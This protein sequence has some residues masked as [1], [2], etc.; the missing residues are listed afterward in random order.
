[1]RLPPDLMCLTRHR[2]SSDAK[3]HYCENAQFRGTTRLL[4]RW[5]ARVRRVVCVRG[6]SLSVHAWPGRPS[7]LAHIFFRM[8]VTRPA[9][10]WNI[11]IILTTASSGAHTTDA[12]SAKMRDHPH[13]PCH[14]SLY[15]RVYGRLTTPP[16]NQARVLA[17]ANTTPPQVPSAQTP[18]T[19]IRGGGGYKMTLVLR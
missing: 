16:L 9:E 14:F 18:L 19:D 6:V 13:P 15:R 17:S 4:A 10:H 2:R 3:R 1:M 5:R 12:R 11:T 7:A 8:C